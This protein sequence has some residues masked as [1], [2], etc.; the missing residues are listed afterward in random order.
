MR[1]TTLAKLVVILIISLPIAAYL[2]TT[3]PEP[4][5][6][7]LNY[8][9]VLLIGKLSG[10]L[11]LMLIS[12]NLVLAG[13]YRSLDRAFN[14]LDKLMGFHHKIGKTAGY[15][16]LIHASAVNFANLFISW[17]FF[18]SELTDVKN[19]PVNLGK[20]AL[21]ILVGILIYTLYA[22]VKY[23][24][25][26]KVHKYIGVVLLLGIFHAFFVDTDLAD[27][28]LLMVV[29]Y[30]IALFAFVSYL[31]RNVLGFRKRISYKISSVREVT[32]T[33]NEIQMKPVEQPLDFDQYSPGQFAFFKFYSKSLPIEDH[34]FTISYYNDGEISISPKESGDYTERFNEL[35]VGEEIEIEGPFGGFTPGSSSHTK[36]VWIAGGIGITP[37]LATLRSIKSGDLD[38]GG[39]DIYLY[40]SYSGDENSAYKVQIRE[41]ADSYENLSVTF[42]DTS[43][44][45]RLKLSDCF[46]NDAKHFLCGPPQLIRGFIGQYDEVKTEESSLSYELFSL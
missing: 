39:K 9:T 44:E 11:G 4:S 29:T 26:K 13:R 21:T 31:V 28:Y 30:P 42:I 17:D 35:E 5:Q 16:L 15:S 23:E 36:E 32:E 3:P 34:P 19:I 2:V 25:F 18:I 1:K 33:V 14:G 6:L 38:V 7:G 45:E 41:I 27:N 37:F 46:I 10:I 40:Y 22:D 20:L 43:I 24:K 8:F 12:V